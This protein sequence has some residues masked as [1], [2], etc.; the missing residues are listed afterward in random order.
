LLKG[1]DAQNFSGCNLIQVHLVI[2]AALLAEKNL[3]IDQYHIACKRNNTGGYVFSDVFVTKLGHVLDQYRSCGLHSATIHAFENKLLINY[4]PYYVLRLQL[5]RSNDLN[6]T[7]TQDR[8]SV[9]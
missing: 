9:V 2:K 4:Y 6:P 1:I 5:A 8:K 3:Y 7:L